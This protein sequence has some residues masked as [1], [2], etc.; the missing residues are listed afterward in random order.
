MTI[1]HFIGL[2]ET[3]TSYQTLKSED[4]AKAKRLSDDIRNKWD[5]NMQSWTSVRLRLSIKLYTAPDIIVSVFVLSIAHEKFTSHWLNA[6]NTRMNWTL[7]HFRLLAAMHVSSPDTELTMV[8]KY[9]Y[10]L[11]RKPWSFY[12]K[13]RISVNDVLLTLTEPPPPSKPAYLW[14]KQ[15][16]NL[17]LSCFIVRFFCLYLIQTY[18]CENHFSLALSFASD[19]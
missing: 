10:M 19:Y 9:F 6:F 5:I 14:I 2:V 11:A 3:F 13:S 18:Q 12:C 8:I 7:F 15:N 17:K 1:N 4:A 16:P